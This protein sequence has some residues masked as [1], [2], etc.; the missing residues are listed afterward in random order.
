[1]ADFSRLRSVVEA[2]AALGSDERERFLERE[3]RGDT[4]LLDEARELLAAAERASDL[5]PPLPGLVEAVAEAAAEV[6]APGRPAPERIGSFRILR[7]LGSGG[8]GT[9]FEAEQDEPR[10]RVAVKVLRRDLGGDAATDRFRHEV[11]TLASLRHP[12]VAQVYETGV[13]VDGVGGETPWFAME[14]V[15]GARTLLRAA[16]EDGFDRESRLR[17][18]LRVAEAV[19]HGHQKGVVHRDLKPDNILIDAEGN[20]KV[21]DFGIALASEAG[22]D[23]ERL[24]Q[25]GQL[26]GT[27]AYM[28][29]EQLAGGD[30]DTSSDVYGL[31]VCLYELLLDRLPIDVSGASLAAIAE[32]VGGAPPRRA[33]ELGRDLEAVLLRAL[34]KDRERR[35]PTVAAFADDVR[36]VLAREPV[37]AR[38]PTA[39]YL[40]R[41]FA[42][43]H[44][45]AFGAATLVFLAAL[46]AAGVSL[47]FALEARRAE[48]ESR[49]LFDALLERSSRITDDFADELIL[50]TGGVDIGRRL[51]RQTI[52][53]LEHLERRSGGAPEVRR[54]VAHAWFR[55]GAF[56]ARLE[57]QAL[58]SA[59]RGLEA[60]ARAEEIALELL[61]ETPGDR[62]LSLLLAR[63]RLDRGLIESATRGPDA[64]E[65]AVLAAREVLQ[66]LL[67]A[68]PNDADALLELGQSFDQTSVAHGR[69]GDQ[70]Q[71]R[72]DLAEARRLFER[73]AAARPGDALHPMRYARTFLT[74]GA[75]FYVE[76]R[77]EEAAAEYA[78]VERLLRPR[79]DEDPTSIPLRETLGRALLFGGEAERMQVHLDAA[80]RKLAA[81]VE[82][83]RALHAD[84]AT[85]PQHEISIVTLAH[86]LGIVEREAGDPERAATW[87]NEGIAVLDRLAAEGRLDARYASMPAAL[88]AAL[89]TLDR[90]P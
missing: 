53:D 50:L 12:A 83:Y 68:D 55:L 31:G 89:K 13:H 61:G 46:V 45:V 44:R 11:R 43:R 67:A 15:D 2:A 72:A 16:R 37:T 26:V 58:D 28:S 54:R 33:P 74:S 19:Q 79:I 38:A 9:V 14:F 35:Y 18:F 81:G 88:Q 66:E 3:C 7:V 78:E 64:S 51:I 80:R 65:A 42:R 5:T 85:N 22:G 76:E 39:A 6:A 56:E 8:M 10:R 84:E 90:S 36:R 82:V 41:A 17:L 63:T 57:G 49:E 70:E 87:F 23:S 25:D 75:S 47:R 71:L 77:Y 59:E 52:D 69:R 20:P 73:F 60:L 34:E 1:M 30:I 48:D 40:A 24:T 32:R 86:G 27:P 29:P 4:A 21:I 62:E